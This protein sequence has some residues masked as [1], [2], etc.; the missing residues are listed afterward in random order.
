M[1]RFALVAPIALALSAA[2]S[3]GSTARD[4]ADFEDLAHDTQP[5]SGDST[6]TSP[7]PVEGPALGLNDLT[8]LL[9]PETFPTPL[10]PPELLL[11][12]ALFNALVTESGDVIT[13]YADL[14]PVAVR[15]DLCDRIVPGPCPADA[16]ASLRVVL[17]PR[18]TPI[19]APGPTFEDV[20]VHAFYPI[21]NA[22]LPTLV[23]ALRELADL[24]QIPF[25]TPL[26]PNPALAQEP[27]GPYRAKLAQL[28][29]DHAAPDRLIRL[30][31]FAQF[32]IRAALVWLFRGVE[33]TSLDEPLTRIAIPDV[34]AEQQD[35]LLV[36]RNSYEVTPVADAPAGLELALSEFAFDAATSAR[37]QE[38][39]DALAQIDSPAAHT[40]HTT[41]CANCHVT[42]QL[43][44]HR[45]A[46]PAADSGPFTPRP[47]DPESSMDRS[48]RALG[49]VFSAPVVSQRAA[50][51]TAAVAV[52]LESRFPSTR[53]AR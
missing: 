52:E 4:A 21:P 10:V 24:G 42:T 34:D 41:Q 46:A 2:C 39:L 25:S 51:E 15:F 18:S 36:G 35:V 43:A 7:A 29:R 53:P 47:Y 37:K 12:E 44:L 17:Q 20:A 40:A 14:V 9:P 38:A 1:N 50:N 48:L 45:G 13:D 6:D 28:V 26:S 5:D 30:T 32:S 27:N 22:E 49:Y 31:A 33:R 19:G 8:F 16:D 23:A 11:D 3:D